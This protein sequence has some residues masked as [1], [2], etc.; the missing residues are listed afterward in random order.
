MIVDDAQAA[1]VVSMV[2]ALDN[3][4]LPRHMELYHSSFGDPAT[5]G[6]VPGPGTSISNRAFEKGFVRSPPLPIS[7][8]TRSEQRQ[9]PACRMCSSGPSSLKSDPLKVGKFS[10]RT[11]GCAL[12]LNPRVKYWHGQLVAVWQML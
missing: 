4:R 3:Q 10:D 9:C 7:A 1:R 8:L 2:T 6:L 12:N 11:L 5:P